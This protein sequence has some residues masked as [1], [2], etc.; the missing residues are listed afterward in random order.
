MSTAVV[1]KKSSSNGLQKHEPTNSERFT[2]RVMSEFKGTAGEG[3]A[4][5]NYQ[6][7]LVQNYFIAVDQALKLAEEKRLQKSEEYR[8]PLEYT[9]KNVHLETLTL[10]VVA[11]A[12]IGFDPAQNNHVSLVPFKNK[13]TNKYEI[14]F[15]PGYR[16]LELKAK[17]YGLDIPDFTVVELVHK[18]DYFK[19]LKKD[20]NNKVE[21]YIFQVAENPFDRGEVIGGFY[22]HGFNSNEQKNRLV[23]WDVTEIEKRKPSYASAEFWGGEKDNWV[24]K[25]GRNVKDGTTKI[26]GWRNIMLWKTMYR[27]AFNSVTIDSEKIDENY[28]KLLEN[29]RQATELISDDEITRNA[30]KKEVGF[31]DAQVMEVPKALNPAQEHTKIS[32]DAAPPVEASQ[33]AENAASA[34]SA[35]PGTQTK[36]PFA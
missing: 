30:N 32:H 20:L 36:A 19:P 26:D 24:K 2:D 28:M 29:E 25:D 4:L 18:N 11:F 27:A 8:D 31:D 9:W 12:R 23:F 35:A 15:I 10:R 14:T 34:E 22:Y 33:P 6:K 3:L 13:H 16:G 7:R 5:S 21:S 17:K 1:E